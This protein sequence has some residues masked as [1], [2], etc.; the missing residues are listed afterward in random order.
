MREEWR[1]THHENYEVSKRGW[2]GGRDATPRTLKH[3]F[4]GDGNRGGYAS[5][6][7]GNG[8]IQLVHRLVAVAFLGPLPTGH[9]VLHRDDD[10]RNPALSNLRYGTH[11][12]NIQEAVKRGRFLNSHAHVPRERG[13]FVKAA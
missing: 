6:Q 4:P 9:E 12:E 2:Q 3:I 7:F 5:V 11:S 13:R 1:A 10:K 8:N